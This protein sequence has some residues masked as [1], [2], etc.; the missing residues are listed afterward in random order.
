MNWLSGD[1]VELRPVEPED[2]DALL[3]WE[4]DPK[5]WELSGTLIPFS[6]G[7][8]KRYIE[9]AHLSIY[10]NGQQRFIIQLK[11]TKEAIGTID[12]FDFDPFQKRAGIGILIGNPIHRAKGFAAA[13]LELL[14]SYCFHHLDMHQLFCN[15]LT[16]NKNSLKLFEKAGFQITGCKKEWVRRGDVFYDEYLLQLIRDK[17]MNE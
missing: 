13:S 10:Q 8:M 14:I 5:N 6:R 16:E 4:N 2:L 3:K 11:N 15:I 9:S 12:L 17:S 7:L 1:K